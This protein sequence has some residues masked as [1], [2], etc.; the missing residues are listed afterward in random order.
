MGE[1]GSDN[2][3]RD[4]TEQRI[5]AAQVSNQ[6]RGDAAEAG[7]PY[8]FRDDLRAFPMAVLILVVTALLLMLL[9]ML[10]L[11]GVHAPLG[12]SWAQDDGR[13]GIELAVVPLMVF[14]ALIPGPVS[15]SRW[16]I[17]VA[18]LRVHRIGPWVPLLLS[19]VLAGAVLLFAWSWLASESS[20]LDP[21]R[22]WFLLL[23]SWSRGIFLD[24][25]LSTVSDSVR[26]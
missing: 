3:E 14:A 1:Q 10:T 13:R 16:A 8:S 2:G 17:R 5:E 12:T 7:A 9:G 6:V 11:A 18:A 22:M 23:N 21:R 15:S 24:L 25:S 4:E 19:G 20:H 26:G